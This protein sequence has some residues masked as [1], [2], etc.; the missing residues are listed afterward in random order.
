MENGFVYLIGAGPGDFK[1]ITVRGLE[2]LKSADIVIYDALAPVSLLNETRPD[3]ELIYVGKRAGHH[4]MK[5]EEINE[6]LI[7]KAKTEHKIVARLKGG[8]PYIF[9]RGGEEALA[10]CAQG[11]D[12]EVIPGVSSSYAVPACNGIPVTHRKMAS[13]FHVITGHEDAKK[14]ASVLDYETLAKEEGTLVFLMGLRN[15]PHI[16]AQLM[17]FGKDKM[18]PAAVL[19]EGTTARQRMVCSTLEDISEAVVRENIKAPAITVIG[20]VVKL[21][22]QLDRSGK[23]P[24]SGRRIL[25]TGTPE[26]NQNLSRRIANLG[27]EPISMSLIDTRPLRNQD[28][29]NVLHQ[30]NMYT[31][32]VLTSKKGVEVFFE[33]IKQHHIDVRSLALLRFAVIG[34]ETGRVLES[35]GIFP[36]CQPERHSSAGLAD[37]LIPMLKENDRVLL[38]RAKQA[39]EELTE[40]LHDAGI[41]YT[42]VSTYETIV[43]ERRT[44]A[45]NRVLTD[46][47]DI[48]FCSASSVRAFVKMREA[49]TMVNTRSKIICIGPVTEQA[50]LDEGLKVDVTAKRYDADG[51]MECLIQEL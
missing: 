34:K 22:D 47:D 45:L 6:L 49:K 39:S 43:D 8:D 28:F 35:H 36:D 17:A 21:S 2:A 31:W 15:L 46:V 48:L 50:A 19:Q 41:S 13:S 12:F 3:A 7:Q 5:Q 32:I 16:T 4:S 24:L 37:A 44:E 40:R 33:A 25:L 11:I 10:L 23:K 14:E 20:D 29:E 27:G 26:M 1:L 9:G 42:Q 51:L 38:A 30:L 18:T